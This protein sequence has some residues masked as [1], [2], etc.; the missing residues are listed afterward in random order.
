MTA[1]TAAAHN[2]A[3]AVRNLRCNSANTASMIGIVSSA[4]RETMTNSM[5]PTKLRA[6][7]ASSTA[8]PILFA[9]SNVITG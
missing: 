2:A 6:T 7:A 5:L 8:S 3:I 1:S 9:R 4:V